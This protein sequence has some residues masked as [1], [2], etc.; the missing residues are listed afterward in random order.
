MISATFKKRVDVVFYVPFC[1]VQKSSA[2]KLVHSGKKCCCKNN[3]HLSAQLCYI[4]HMQLITFIWMHLA[5]CPA[6]YHSLSTLL[7]VSEVCT[8]IRYTRGK[9]NKGVLHRVISQVLRVFWKK[10]GN[11]IIYTWLWKTSSPVALWPFA[12]RSANSSLFR[13]HTNLAFKSPKAT[14]SQLRIKGN[15]MH[16]RLQGELIKLITRTFCLYN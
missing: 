15:V 14:F 7:R 10:L 6:L 4:W 8:P 1:T 5:C 13:A 16:T 3:W 12:I 11:K 2:Y 9:V